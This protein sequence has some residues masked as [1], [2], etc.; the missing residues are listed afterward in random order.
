MIAVC[1]GQ[2][3]DRDREHM[4]RWFR[5]AMEADPDNLQACRDKLYYLYPRWHGSHRE[6]ISFAREC[7]AT[8][9]EVGGLPGC[10]AAV[11]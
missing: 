10:R 5:R 8:E 11:C 3:S 4:E 7:L 2:D 6:M 9:A 1:L